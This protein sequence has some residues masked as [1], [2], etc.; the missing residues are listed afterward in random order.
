MTTI[1]TIQGTEK[2]M[3]EEIRAFGVTANVLT[4]M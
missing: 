4:Y 1:E 2:K 3:D